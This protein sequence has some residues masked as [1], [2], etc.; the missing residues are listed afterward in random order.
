MS[1]LSQDITT[2]T[3]APHSK[4][5][6]GQGKHIWGMQNPE[7]SGL[8]SWTKNIREGAEAFKVVKAPPDFNS[9][10][11]LE[12]V[13]TGKHFETTFTKEEVESLFRT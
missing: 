13:V 1:E 2:A 11:R 4:I 3:T 9:P 5:I 10:F 7:N 12:H 8:H 6:P